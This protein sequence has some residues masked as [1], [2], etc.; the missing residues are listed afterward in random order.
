MKE[1]NLELD[2]G[3][4]PAFFITSH[5]NTTE[6]NVIQQKHFYSNFTFTEIGKQSKAKQ[7]KAKAK[8]KHFLKYFHE[9]NVHCIW[10]TANLTIHSD[11]VIQLTDWYSTSWNF[12]DCNCNG[13]H[14]VG[15]GV[16]VVLTQKRKEVTYTT[17][18]MLSIQRL[19]CLK[20]QLH[21]FIE[22][23]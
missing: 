20:W 3:P 8:Q 19:K 6:C 13:W 7:S 4:V 11:I 2:G 22:E 12:S 9:M 21:H 10:L 23:D 18:I 1:D 5:M 16:L 15:M 14:G 17:S